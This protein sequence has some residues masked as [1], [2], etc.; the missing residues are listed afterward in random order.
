MEETLQ[1]PLKAATF[2]TTGYIYFVGECHT[3]RIGLSELPQASFW[4][5]VLVL[6]LS[7]ANQF[8]FTRKLNSFSYE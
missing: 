5:R 7:Y 4:K 3:D 1:R 8:S 2:R 6:I